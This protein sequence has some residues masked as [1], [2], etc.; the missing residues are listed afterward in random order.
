[1]DYGDSHGTWDLLPVTNRVLLQDPVSSPWR[2]DPWTQMKIKFV[3][4]YQWPEYIFAQE[5][6][7]FL[8]PSAIHKLHLDALKVWIGLTLYLS[9]RKSKYVSS[10]YIIILETYLLIFFSL[11]HSINK[12]WLLERI[13]T[14]MHKHCL[15]DGWH[16]FFKRSPS[17]KL[18][19]MPSYPSSLC[20]T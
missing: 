6:G 8:T 20:H 19:S 1:M 15:R 13:V 10:K 2:I 7:D 12:F 17:S 16:V 14:S 3:G 5:L 11:L 18:G 4:K 9:L